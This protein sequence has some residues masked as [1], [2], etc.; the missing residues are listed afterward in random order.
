MGVRDYLDKNQDL[1][2]ETFLAA[3]RRQIER[4]L[5]AKRHRQFTRGLLQFRESVEKILPLVRSATALNDPV[6]LPDAVRHLFRFLIRTTGSADGV[7]LGRHTAA[8][9]TEWFAAFGPDGRQLPAPGVPF[10]RSLAATVLSMNEACAMSA[11]DLGT[12]GAVE[13]QSFE[14]GRSSILAAPIPVAAGTHVVVELFDKPGGFTPED[15]KLVAGSGEF[16]GEI[17]RQA[18]AERQTQRLLIDAVEA[19]LK[20]S[21][22]VTGL[23]PAAAETDDAPLPTAVM[24]RLRAGLGRTANAVVDADTSLRLAE[25]V[26]ELAVRHGPAAVAHCVRMVESVRAMLDETAE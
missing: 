18:L 21:E 7:L 8:D 4:I 20:A 22:D 23:P 14:R 10:N 19:A 1:N 3:V 11:A 6:P 25:A 9:G 5:P 2:R 12:L 17:L 24:D 16:A 15:R 26:R 13:L